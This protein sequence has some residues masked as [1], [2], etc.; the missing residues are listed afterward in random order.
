MD[1]NTTI[2]KLEENLESA[3]HSGDEKRIAAI[4]YLINHVK[5]NRL[6]WFHNGF[7]DHKTGKWH[8]MKPEDAEYLRTCGR[9]DEEIVEYV[10][11]REKNDMDDLIYRQDAI[12]WLLEKGQKS[13]RY[14]FGEKWELNFDEI[15]DALS[16]VPE[17]NSLGGY[18]PFPGYKFDKNSESKFEVGVNK[19]P[20]NIAD[21]DAQTNMPDINDPVNHPAHYTQGGIECIGAIEAAC[22][23]LDG[24]EGYLVGQVIKYIWRW[25]HKNSLQDLEKAKWYLERLIANVGKTT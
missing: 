13:E 1:Y 4:K 23:G 6:E 22:T 16:E 20:V 25:K 14:K 9:S 11:L 2:S 24:K 7:Y 21:L 19:E 12:S 8:M 3:V 15:R 10:N 17:A 18:N 5:K